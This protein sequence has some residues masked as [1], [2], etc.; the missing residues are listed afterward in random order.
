MTINWPLVIVLLG[1]SIPGIFIAIKRLIYFLL[2]DNTE[3]LKK[4][5]S[6]YAVLQTLVMVFMLSLAGAVLAPSTGLHAVA[7]EALLNGTAGIKILAPIILPALIYA[8][9]ALIIFCILYYGL[10]KRV[11]DEKSMQI[12]TNL[13]RALGVDGCVLYGGVTEEVIGRWGLMNLAV[14]FALIL[15]KEITPTVM[16]LSI[17]ISSLIFA[18]GQLPAYLA[19]G[20]ASS[21]Q[22]IY[23][24]I[25]LSLSQSIIF[26]Y[27][28][29]KYGLLCAILTHMLFHL[30]WAL[31]D[32]KHS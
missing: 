14:F 10:A 29:W 3:E 25:L 24:Y 27:V 20:C 13:R 17:M 18:I 4:R 16:W 5:I 19:A 8:A 21:R 12:I 26:G 28:F 22:F 6:S 30:G 23:T 32:S 31:F 9:V 1:I 11:M 2:P 15:T 7:L